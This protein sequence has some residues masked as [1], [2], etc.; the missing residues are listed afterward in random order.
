MLNSRTPTL[1][2]S[3]AG[4][5]PHKPR[6]RQWTKSHRLRLHTAGVAKHHRSSPRSQPPLSLCTLLPLP[7]ANAQAPLSQQWQNTNAP[8]LCTLP[9]LLARTCGRCSSL[10]GL[11]FRL[12]Y[13]PPRQL[14]APPAWT[15]ANTCL[16]QTK[17]SAAKLIGYHKANALGL[18]RNYG[19]NTSHSTRLSFIPFLLAPQPRLFTAAFFFFFSPFFFLF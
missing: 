9:P 19:I 8:M 17:K 4:K 10:D 6:L 16:S 5:P 11:A 12:R 18:T 15:A 14:I 1:L 2:R 3:T 7:S 13:T